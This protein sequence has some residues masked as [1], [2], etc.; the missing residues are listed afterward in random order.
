MH[1]RGVSRLLAAI[2]L[3]TPLVSHAE[4]HFE[5]A[6]RLL[7]AGQETEARRALTLEIGT[8]P[9]NLE[10]RYNLAVLLER[11][12][13]DDK[14]ALLYR[15][16]IKRGKHLPS[17]INLSAWLRRNRQGKEA[18]ELLLKAS[19]IFRSEAPPWYLLAEMAEQK[20]ELEQADRLYRKAIKADRKNGFAHLRYAGFLNRS[21]HALGAQS[22]ANQAI[23]RLPSC[24]SCLH[25][26]ADIFHSAGKEHRALA[27]WQKSIAIH[28][29]A[30][31]RN[32]IM[33]AQQA[34]H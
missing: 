19:R 13:H 11:I 2:L 26:A 31:L 21:G 32:K 22:H 9:G 28:P 4:S 12:G 8:R 18:E 20:N 14:A 6:E 7:Q 5:A 29:D 34:M 23:A 27:L 33:Q 1:R 25:I 10:A 17:M 24:G 15:E 3:F 16:N 30:E